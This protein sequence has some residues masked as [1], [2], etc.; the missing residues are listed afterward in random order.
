MLS[1]YDTFKKILAGDCVTTVGD[2]SYLNRWGQHDVESI[3]NNEFINYLVRNN[4]LDEDSGNFETGETNFY[5]NPEFVSVDGGFRTV[6]MWKVYRQVTEYRF[7]P[8]AQRE[9]F[10]QIL[11]KIKNAE[12]RKLKLDKLAKI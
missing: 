12:L 10:I 2:V 5:L 6:Y 3:L 4:I 9:L 7:S 1:N 8:E 11:D